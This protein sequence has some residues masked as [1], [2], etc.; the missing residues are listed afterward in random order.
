LRGKETMEGRKEVR[1]VGEKRKKE[2]AMNR[3]V[4]V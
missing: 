2:R 3:R 4:V 1:K